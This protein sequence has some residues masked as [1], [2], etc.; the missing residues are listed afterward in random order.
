MAQWLREFSIGDWYQAGEESFEI[1]GIDVKS[2]VVLV[3][4]YN[5]TL[6]EVDFETW[7]QLEA[8]PRAAPEDMSGALDAEREDFGL[9]EDFATGSGGSAVTW[10]EAH[11][12]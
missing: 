6:D 4:H 2:E 1:V 12:L 3:Q 5:G 8:R 7:A 11:N 10:L 9:E